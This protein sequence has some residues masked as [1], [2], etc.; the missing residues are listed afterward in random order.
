MM[1]KERSFYTEKL[2]KHIAKSRKVRE[3]ILKLM[4]KPKEARLI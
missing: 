2:K 1:E 3:C 4:T